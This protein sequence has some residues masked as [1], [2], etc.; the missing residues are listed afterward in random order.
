MMRLERP[1]MESTVVRKHRLSTPRISHWPECQG[2]E[3][4]GPRNCGPRV[5]VTAIS[6]SRAV[7]A[8]EI[9]E[10]LAVWRQVALLRIHAAPKPL[11]ARE[12]IPFRIPE[13]QA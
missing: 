13:R 5:V 7:F 9:R 6:C 2:S 3:V 4:W 11:A 12:V 10:E 1:D 8:R